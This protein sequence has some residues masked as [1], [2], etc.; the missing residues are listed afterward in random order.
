MSGA[1][2]RI[3]TMT[4]QAQSDR[5]DERIKQIEAINLRTRKMYSNSIIAMV[6]AFLLCGVCLIMSAYLLF[7]DHPVA[8]TVFGA[9]SFI[10]IL[11]YFLGPLRN[12][13]KKEE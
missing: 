11:R 6:F 5:H 10:A 1:F 12:K 3:L 8:G 13:D 7:H 9:P 4:E 2:N